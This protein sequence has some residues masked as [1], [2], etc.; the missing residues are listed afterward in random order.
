MN[1]V[2]T[3]SLLA[4]IALLAAG[5]YSSARADNLNDYPTAARVDY[6]VRLHESLGETQHTLDQCSCSIDIITSILP[7]DRYVESRAGILAQVPGHLGSQFRSTEIAKKAIEACARPGHAITLLTADAAGC[8]ANNRGGGPKLRPPISTASPPTTK[9]ILAIRVIVLSAHQRDCVKVDINA[10]A[11]FL[12]RKQ[13]GRLRIGQRCC[14]AISNLATK[15]AGNQFRSALQIREK[16]YIGHGRVPHSPLRQYRVQ[17]LGHGCPSIFKNLHIFCCVRKSEGIVFC[18]RFQGRQLLW[19]GC[20]FFAGEGKSER[21]N[22]FLATCLR[23]DTLPEM[24]PQAWLRREAKLAC[25]WLVRIGAILTR[26][27][28]TRDALSFAYA[29]YLPRRDHGARRTRLRR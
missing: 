20:R 18:F 6:G 21:E 26:R 7:Y 28:R 25:S 17:K 13:R 15:S 14:P 2:E 22:D 23:C 19:E 16:A 3:L 10:S 12:D 9:P 24:L 29:Q 4:R 5:A 8:W 11:E 1:G 27:R